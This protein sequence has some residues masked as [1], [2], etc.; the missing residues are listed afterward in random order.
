ML[1]SEDGFADSEGLADSMMVGTCEGPLDGTGVGMKEILGDND[2]SW[3][4]RKVRVGTLDGPTLG[5]VVGPNDGFSDGLALE[6]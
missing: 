2:G 4:G 1:G 5:V 6:F 3:L